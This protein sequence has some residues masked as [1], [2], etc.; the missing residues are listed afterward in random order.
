MAANHIMQIIAQNAA[1]PK[2]AVRLA[3]AAGLE[4]TKTEVR[5]LHS[6]QLARRAA[7][8]RLDPLIVA[9]NSRLNRRASVVA[10]RQALA[11]KRE[12]DRLAQIEFDARL[13]AAREARAARRAELRKC[14]IL[15]ARAARSLGFA[16]RSSTDRHGLVSSY[17]VSAGDKKIRLSDHDIPATAMRDAAS[18]ERTGS[19]YTGFQGPELILDQPRR[20]LWLRRAITL[21]ANG[22]ALPTR[23]E[24]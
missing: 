7:R 23:L 10:A 3:R 18:Y 9:K 4:I 6:T 21:L 17:Y 15:A 16:V 11:E 12:A 1:S 14:L 2:T 20:Y 19:F 5:A 13:E 24:A 8:F 22:R